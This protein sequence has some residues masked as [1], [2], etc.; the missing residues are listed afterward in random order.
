M[1]AD[2]VPLSPIERVSLAEEAAF[3]VTTEI[4]VPDSQER[5]FVYKAPLSKA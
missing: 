4:C 3:L 5:L 2:L 1:T